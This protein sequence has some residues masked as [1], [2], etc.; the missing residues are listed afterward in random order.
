MGRKFRKSQLNLSTRLFVQRQTLHVESS[1]HEIAK[2]SKIV[3]ENQKG[4]Q[5]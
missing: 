2:I 4:K 3:F 1:S 5:A